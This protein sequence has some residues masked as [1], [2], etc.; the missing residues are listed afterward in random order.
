MSYKHA[1]FVKQLKTGYNYQIKVKEILEKKGL[2]VTID[3][4]RIRPEYGKRIDYTDK[5]DLF[6]Y[7]KDIKIPLEIKSSSR[8]YTSM[9]DYPYNDVIVDMVDNWDNKTHKPSAI[10]NISQKTLSTFVIN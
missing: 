3:K 6:V 7:K 2:K 9:L 10:I 1:D 8:E 5:G 4:L